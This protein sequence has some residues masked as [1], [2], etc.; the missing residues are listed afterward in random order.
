MNFGPPSVSSP[1]DPE[2]AS[3]FDILAPEN[4]RNRLVAD[5]G[6]ALGVWLFFQITFSLS[7]VV[8]VVSET[9]LL[10]NGLSYRGSPQT[11]WFSLVMVFGGQ[12][13]S[14]ADSFCPRST[15]NLLSGIR[16][17][18][19]GRRFSQRIWLAGILVAV[20][21]TRRS[22]ELVR[23]PDVNRLKK[24]SMLNARQQIKGVYHV[25]YHK[26]LKRSNLSSELPNSV[27]FRFHT[28]SCH[29]RQQLWQH[30]YSV[31]GGNNKTSNPHTGP[32]DGKAARRHPRK[33]SD[34]FRR[35]MACAMRATLGEIRGIAAIPIMILIFNMCHPRYIA[36]ATPQGGQIG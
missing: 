25:G 17:A 32:M 14:L 30:R 6:G 36:A 26:I 15:I 33:L 20:S 23:N 2:P 22:C 28:G 16:V 8:L 10:D 1:P 19:F 4:S 27:D 7:S 3:P 9:G 5:P 24:P 13:G 11:R 29:G 34:A 18:L 35:S 12:I 31:N 21:P